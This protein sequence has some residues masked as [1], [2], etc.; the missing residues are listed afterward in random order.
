MKPNPLKTSTFIS[1]SMLVT[2]ITTLFYSTHAAPPPVGTAFTYQGRLVD[3]GSPANGNY[4]LRF[5]LYNALS[6][7]STIGVPITS[8]P[9]AVSNGLFTVT[10]DFGGG[11]FS[12]N[13]RWLEMG[14]RTNGSV[15]AY[16]LLIP[17][18]ELTPT[19]YALYAPSAGAATTADTATTANSVASGSINNPALAVGAVNS[20]SIADASIAANDLSA[21]LLSNI[22]F[23]DHNQTFT[24]ANIFDRGNG[25]PG[26]LIVQGNYPVDTSMFT[27]LGFQYNTGPGE[28]AIMS[29]YNDGYAFLSFYTKAGLGYPIAKK[30]IID[31]WGNVAVDQGNANNGILNNSTTSGAGLTFGTNSG[32]GIASK[33][34]AG[35]NQNG[36]DFYTGFTNRMSIANTGNVGIGT[37][38]PTD[39][40][41][42]EGDVRLN[43]HDLLFAQGADRFHG[44]G[45]YG[46]GK[47]FAGMNVDGPV[48]YGFG[49]GG[50]GSA[51]STNLALRWIGNGQVI[52][53]PTGLN[54]GSVTPGLTFGASS[55]EGIASKHTAGG[56]QNGLD[57]YTGFT[58]RMSIANTGNVGIGTTTPSSSLHVVGDTRI[59]GVTRAGSETGTAQ[60]PDKGII[61]RRVYSTDT[62][63]GSVVARTDKL[64]LQRDGSASGLRIVNVALPGHITIAFTGLT[65]AGATVNFVMSFN[66]A[67]AGT[68][69]VFTDAQNVVYLRGSFG[70]SYGAGHMTEVSLT[71]YSGDFF[72]MGTLTSTF[73]Q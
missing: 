51:G 15:L 64:T 73:N 28:G 36:L 24:G 19:P 18:Q 56:N 38:S 53:D 3:N 60:A 46:A 4:D 10:L 45:W 12:G 34:T 66:P 2:V 6:G 32:A 20:S 61:T 27:G 44:L 1:L 31:Q 33:R 54:A 9:T 11:I 69:T 40:L 57:F 63:A 23:L 58:N 13:A 47:L 50:L 22:A 29:S 49:G 65:G 72:W 26:R 68:N 42:V 59:T 71:R 35:G 8:A 52:I 14:V 16:T 37:S 43:N 17:R 62:T 70:D 55:G 67:A 48:L 41:D 5:T 21:A 25:G 39:A 30:M 7:G